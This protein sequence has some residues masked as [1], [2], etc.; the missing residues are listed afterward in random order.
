MKNIK[1]SLVAAAIG[2]VVLRFIAGAVI[3]EPRDAMT[4]EGRIIS[5]AVQGV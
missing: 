3:D 2:L 4:G 1:R 5:Y